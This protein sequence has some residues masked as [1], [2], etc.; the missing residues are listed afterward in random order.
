MPFGEFKDFGDY[1]DSVLNRESI[2]KLTNGFTYDFNNDAIENRSNLGEGMVN[3]IG[4][5]KTNISAVSIGT[6]FKY[7]FFLWE[8]ILTEMLKTL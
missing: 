5:Y 6:M 4:F 7:K 3:D 8:N 2:P 1:T